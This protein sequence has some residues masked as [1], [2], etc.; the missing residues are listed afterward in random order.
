MYPH[1]LAKRA[2]DGIWLPYDHL[3]HTSRIITPGIIQGGGRYIIEMPPRHGKSWFCSRWIPIWFL[4][5]FPHK[6]VI[7]SSYSGDLAVDHARE[8]R[9]ILSHNDHL[10][11]KLRVD[12]TASNRFHTTEGGALFA[13]GVGGTITGRGA[14]LFVVDDPLKD[15]EEA[16]SKSRREKIKN[17]WDSVADTRLEPGASVIILMTR[18][19]KE[20]LVGHVLS[21]A[22]DD[23]TRIR[24]P[25]LAED[26]DPLGRPIGEAL[27][28]ERYDTA[29]LEKKKRNTSSMIWNA[30]YQQAPVNMEGSV[31][32]DA[33]WQYYDVLP[34]NTLRKIQFWDCAQKPGITNDYSV[35][36]TWVETPTGYYLVDIFRRKME[37][38]DLERAA[39]E[40]YDKH[41]PG[42][43]VIEDKSA[44]S[45]LIQYLRRKT[46]IPVKEFDPGRLDKESRAIAVSPDVESGNVLLPRRAPWLNDYKA[47][48]NDFPNSENDDQVDTTSMAIKYFQSN[49]YAVPRVTVI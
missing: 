25:A 23:W 7:I 5:N 14:H 15:W 20:D 18:W 10:S 27:C 31:F 1:T 2:S 8:V 39:I 46:K 11:V 16:S 43:V 13:V 19:H 37:G 35:C 29:F 32:K 48:H 24:L 36:A 38:P 28:P 30:L 4:E 26:S 44:G 17:W 42:L 21:M 34:L 9:N 41:K 49:P 45:S 47:E 6:N 12:S 40:Q 22:G 3:T 33:W